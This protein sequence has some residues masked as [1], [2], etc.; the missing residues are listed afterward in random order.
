MNQRVPFCC[1]APCNPCLDPG[2]ALMGV[3][4]GSADLYDFISVGR[5]SF[6]RII[7]S[8]FQ[9]PE[10]SP[11]EEDL[12]TRAAGAVELPPLGSNWT[13]ESCGDYYT[14][15]ISQEDANLSSMNKRMECLQTEWPPTEPPTNNQSQP[16][17]Y[18]LIYGNTPVD[19]QTLCTNGSI[20]T[21]HVASGKFFEFTQEQADR[22]A[23]EYAKSFADKFKF[24][25]GDITPG[26]CCVNGDCNPIIAVLGGVPPPQC[27]SPL[28]AFPQP[29]ETVFSFEVLSGE[30]PPGMT[31]SAFVSPAQQQTNAASAPNNEVPATK[32]GDTPPPPDSPNNFSEI[33]VNPLVDAAVQEIVNRGLNADELWW[34]NEVQNVAGIPGELT[35]SVIDQITQNIPT[36]PK[37]TSIPGLGMYVDIGNGKPVYG[38]SNAYPQPPNFITA[39]EYNIIWIAQQRI[40]HPTT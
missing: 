25:L 17:T 34:L 11:Y 12:S 38:S 32:G 22:D 9:T 7:G 2:P 19:Y 23:L 33:P 27:D 21:T 18:R 3:D 39:T 14:S 20:Y 37:G 1:E 10:A 29:K 31:W 5:G 4:S 13:R 35:D 8:P 16:D 40:L 24:C 30:L 26:V 28:D 6:G 15:K 36:F